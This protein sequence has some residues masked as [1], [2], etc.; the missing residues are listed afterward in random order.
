MSTSAVL[1]ASVRSSVLISASRDARVLRSLRISAL[2]DE[3]VLLSVVSSSDNSVTF[4][5]AAVRSRFVAVSSRLS[6]SSVVV[7]GC[8]GDGS[9]G[10]GA[11]DL[12][13]GAAATPTPGRVRPRLGAGAVV[14]IGEGD[15]AG[16]LATGDTGDDVE[17]PVRSMETAH[18][19]RV[20]E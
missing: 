16:R 12:G 5:L 1:E 8:V 13:V 9:A 3:I 10:A 7:G 4:V 15:V 11:R 18:D 17:A 14:V 2:V 6:S 20:V 19:N